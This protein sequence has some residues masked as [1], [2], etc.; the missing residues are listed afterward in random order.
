[1]YDNPTGGTGGKSMLVQRNGGFMLL[2]KS[3]YGNS[4][5]F[6][7]VLGTIVPRE[8]IALSTADLKIMKLSSFSI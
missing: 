6:C 2:I 7:A 1:L 3:L 8:N 5:G 4:C